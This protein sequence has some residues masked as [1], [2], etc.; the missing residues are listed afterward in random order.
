MERV[1]RTTLLVVYQ[2]T[3]LAGIV[4]LPFAV[5]ARRVGLRVPVHRAVE[6]VGERYE[7]V[8]AA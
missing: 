7:Q 6:R 4:L 5:A 8:S 2:L 1:Y 3:L